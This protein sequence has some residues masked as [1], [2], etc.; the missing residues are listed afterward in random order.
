MKNV[1]EL[2]FSIQN[3]EKLEQLDKQKEPRETKK[4]AVS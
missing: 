2:R 4:M 1:S 3:C